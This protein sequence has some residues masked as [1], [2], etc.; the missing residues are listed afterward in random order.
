VRN[1]FSKEDLFKKV[2]CAGPGMATKIPA[3][4]K[5]SRQRNLGRKRQEQ[6]SPAILHKS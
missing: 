2:T 1:I 3:L 5:V 4:K 6:P